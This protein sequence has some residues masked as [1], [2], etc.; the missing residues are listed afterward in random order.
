MTSD[1]SAAQFFGAGPVASIFSAGQFEGSTPQQ[2]TARVTILAQRREINRIRGYKLQL[3]PAEKQKLAEI[4]QK[5]QVIEQKSSNG[6][7]RSDE[8]EDR[9][10]LLAQADEIIGKPSIDAKADDELAKLAGIMEALLNPKLNPAQAKRV[11]ML[12]R[13]KDNIESS[14]LRSPESATLRNQFRNVTSQLLEANPPRPVSSL[15]ITE[16]KAYD[17]LAVLINE[18]AGAK[19]QLSAKE[20]IRVAELESSI[21]NLQALSP[22]NFGQQPTS[23]QVSRA[24]TRL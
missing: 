16:R 6:T 2:E 5:V 15:S 12:R 8:L 3:T 10:D 23:Q 19:I 20:N 14:M 1:V 18:R 22:P 4:Q 24:Y 11:E 7:V 21:I 13:V 17:D 9:T